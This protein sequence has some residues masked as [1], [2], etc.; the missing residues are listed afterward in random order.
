MQKYRILITSFYYHPEIN[1]RAFRTYELVKGFLKMGHS[2]DLLIPHYDYCY[3]NNENLRIIHVGSKHIKEKDNKVK[4][5]KGRLFDFFM[6]HI[7]CKMKRDYD[8]FYFCYG[9]YIH[10]LER[11]LKQIRDEKY[12]IL[13]SIALPFSIHYGTAQFLKKCNPNIRTKI[14][15]YGDPFSS[16]PTFQ[17][18]SKC[19]RIEKKVLDYFDHI[20]VPLEHLTH[21]FKK[22]KEA[23]KIHVIPQGIDI[24]TIKIAPYHKNDVVT[25]G[26]AGTFYDEI[27]NP[28]LLFDFLTQASFDF[29]F[30]I[31]TNVQGMRLISHYIEKLGEKLIVH[32]YIPRNEVIYNMSQMDFLINIPAVVSMKACGGSK[33]MDYALTGRPIF[34]MTQDNLDREKFL[35][36]ISGDYTGKLE[37]D[38][39]QFDTTVVCQKFL[40]LIEM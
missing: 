5:I 10:V 11:A 23:D 33:I 21:E 29:R 24:Q 19:Q 13:I 31:Y 26:Y 40:D 6:Y 32:D 12:D 1:P 34:N 2:V 8:C 37:I 3:E 30:I 36:F 25:F 4:H 15:D 38:V 14:A 7:Y 18:S 22:F 39:N 20:A 28:K 9:T 27:R 16:N 17:V 35:R